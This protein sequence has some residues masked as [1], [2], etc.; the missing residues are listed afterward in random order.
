MDG[1][2]QAN[3]AMAQTTAT[4]SFN[5]TSSKAASL[6]ECS[7][8]T[9]ASLAVGAALL[10]D[11][12]HF[13]AVLQ[14][15]PAYQQEGLSVV[16]GLLVRAKRR[17]VYS[18]QQI[19]A[20]ERQPSGTWVVHIVSQNS[21]VS[22]LPV[23][24]LSSKGINDT[25]VG[26]QAELGELQSRWPSLMSSM[27]EVAQFQWQ[28]EGSLGLLSKVLAK[29]G[30][31]EDG[32]LPVGAKALAA[33]LLTLR[34]KR[35]SAARLAALQAAAA[36]PA[37]HLA[38]HAAA[39]ERAVAGSMV[40]HLA[41]PVAVLVRVA[42]PAASPA[43]PAASHACI[44]LSD[45][46]APGPDIDRQQVL[47][48]ESPSEGRLKSSEHEGPGLPDHP[49]AEVTAGTPVEGL[50]AAAPAQPG[51]HCSV[52]APQGQQSGVGMAAGQRSGGSTSGELDSLGSN[53]DLGSHSGLIE[54]SSSTAQRAQAAT[55]GRAGVKTTSGGT[56][57]AGGAPRGARSCE[58]HRGDRKAPRSHSSKALAPSSISQGSQSPKVRQLGERS[59]KRSRC[60]QVDVQPS[61]RKSLLRRRA[62]SPPARPA[63]AAGTPAPPLPVSGELVDR[64]ARPHW[65]PVLELE[66]RLALY[67]L[68]WPWAPRPELDDRFH[69]PVDC[70][71]APDGIWWFAKDRPHL[72]ELSY[73]KVGL[74]AGA[75]TFLAYKLH[76]LNCLEDHPPR[77]ALQRLAALVPPPADLAE[78]ADG[79]ELAG[80]EFLQDCMV[81]TG[82]CVEL[83]P[84]GGS[85]GTLP[86][87]PFPP[88]CDAKHG[89][90]C[91]MAASCPLCH[92]EPRDGSPQPHS[93][94]LPPTL[95]PLRPPY[96]AGPP[97]A[98]PGYYAHPLPRFPRW[99][100]W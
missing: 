21:N 80:Y 98:P 12:L 70:W 91:S 72:F 38:V 64:L 88:E 90:R 32:S 43:W 83:R 51:L 16:R 3:T 7:L 42:A 8:A 61:P 99:P 96:A 15:Q 77:M 63:P 47:P 97:Y 60:E 59:S 30:R 79:M 92:A 53:M 93:P 58:Q 1:L 55:C 23:R 13:E 57:G 45:N 34:D 87:P 26:V 74:K 73:G 33:L 66:C 76:L 82:G 84:F 4:P 37:S 24:F 50:G 17:G 25:E 54:P 28:L 35:G 39:H 48:P 10:A 31:A 41:Q 5:C 100:G 68:D 22:A 75:L 46:R 40:A 20:A 86:P 81:L 19:H 14:G 11:L 69:I 95:S 52:T 44:S 71:F 65:D 49:V 36:A 6:A 56:E 18:W 85:W 9:A 62:L 2:Q 89:R 67:L 94:P 78:A 27:Q 29:Q